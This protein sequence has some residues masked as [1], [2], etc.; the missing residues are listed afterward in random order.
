[1]IFYFI[2]ETHFT[3]KITV[4][5]VQTMDRLNR[6]PEEK[7]QQTSRNLKPETKKEKQNNLHL[8]N[9]RHFFISLYCFHRYFLWIFGNKKLTNILRFLKYIFDFWF[10]LHQFYFD[11]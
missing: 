6:Q 10:L 4:F 5:K 1:M 7:K 2:I 3:Q 9:M 11:L 8:K